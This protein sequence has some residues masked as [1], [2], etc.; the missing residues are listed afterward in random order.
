[1]IVA[2]VIDLCVVVRLKIRNTDPTLLFVVNYAR[3][4]I[5]TM[6]V[7]PALESSSFDWPLACLVHANKWS[8]ALPIPIT[9]F[10][11]LSTE[12][13]ALITMAI[14]TFRLVCAGL[15]RIRLFDIWQHGCWWFFGANSVLRIGLSIA[16]LVTAT[17]CEVE[18]I[19]GSIVQCT[20]W[21]CH[22]DK[23]RS[24]FIPAASLI[25]GQKL[26]FN[27]EQAIGTKA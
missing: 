5:C 11:K 7:P 19:C 8:I 25:R 1:M 18:G 16:E 17:S 10:I 3:L 21:L 12:A 15:T 6:V 13:L 14:H 24:T 2:A 9:A 22:I 27:V 26:V 20:I 23:V 4:G